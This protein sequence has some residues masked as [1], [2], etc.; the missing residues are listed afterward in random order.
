MTRIEPSAPIEAA[1]VGAATPP[2]IEPSTANTSSSGG[3]ATLKKR[4]QSSAARHRVA[5]ARGIGGTLSGRTMPT[6]TMYT[7]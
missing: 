2:M 4:I 3:S 7:Q 5:L 1:S 6:I